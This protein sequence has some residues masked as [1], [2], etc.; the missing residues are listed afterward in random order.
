MFLVAVSFSSAFLKSRKMPR[1]AKYT[2]EKMIT[3]A[4]TV[5]ALKAKLSDDA[6]IVRK[7]KKKDM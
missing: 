4:K 7:M 5:A 3:D 2:N 1:D 6:L